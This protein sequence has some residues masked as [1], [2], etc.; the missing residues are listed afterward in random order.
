MRVSLL[1]TNSSEEPTTTRTP[2]NAMAMGESIHGT[3]TDV[4]FFFFFTLHYSKAF[5]VPD[6]VTCPLLTYQSRSMHELRRLPP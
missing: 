3:T 4:R 6:T 1:E 5:P 2:E